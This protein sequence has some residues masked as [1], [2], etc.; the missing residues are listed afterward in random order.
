MM[1]S[2]LLLSL[3]VLVAS[4]FVIATFIG[5]DGQLLLMTALALLSCVWVGG[6]IGRR[7]LGQG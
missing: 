3:L 2:L 4:P 1:K 5:D 6:C 7:V